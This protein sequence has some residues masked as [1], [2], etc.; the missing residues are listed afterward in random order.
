MLALIALQG[1]EV[2]D[3]GRVT[4][5][6]WPSDMAE[7]VAMAEFADRTTNWPGIEAPSQHR[8]R[9]IVAP[10]NRILDSITAGRLPEWGA[11]AAFPGTNTI[12]VVSGRSSRQVLLHELAHLAL[13]NSVG[14]VPRWFDEGYASL[15]AGEWNRL[16]ALRVNWAIVRGR[17]PSLRTVN[18]DLR[19]GAVRAESGYAL[20]TTAVLYLRRLGGE[21]GLRPIIRAL[22]AE[23]G[24]DGALRSAHAIT[25]DQFETLWQR[26]LRS[27]YGWLL[28]LTSF[29]VFWT[30]VG[31][32]V[33]VIW[34]RRRKRDRLRRDAL[35]IGWTV[36][37]DEPPA[38]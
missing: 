16:E 7:A 22:G 37:M 8:I 6:F 21:Q 38:S 11:G 35:D 4:V 13:R 19:A 27:R 17:V 5:V 15:A 12:V 30:V 32:A 34:A 25:L 29:S 20:A 24:I 33:L 3:V 23:P 28:F 26:D 2:V 14:Q 9:L 18:L 1:L 10:D 31:G 36:S